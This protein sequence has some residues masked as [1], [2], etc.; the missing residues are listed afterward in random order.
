MCSLVFNGR[1]QKGHVH[2]RADPAPEGHGAVPTKEIKKHV[3]DGLLTKD[4][5]RNE[6]ND[7]LS[8]PSHL[9]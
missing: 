4:E 6:R 9:G 1:V 5:N 8:V 3:L 2:K 7:I